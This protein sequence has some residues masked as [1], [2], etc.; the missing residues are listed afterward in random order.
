[1]TPAQE[2]VI[3]AFH[4]IARQ[5]GSHGDGRAKRM[6]THLEPYV[7]KIVAEQAAAKK[8]TRRRTAAKPTAGG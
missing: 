3:A 7:R 8:A 5:F 4:E 1:M 2:E 6:V